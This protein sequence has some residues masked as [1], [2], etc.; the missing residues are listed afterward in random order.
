GN[1]VANEVYC[2]SGQPRQIDYGNGVRTTHGYDA[3][4]RLDALRTI[5]QP[6]TLN[7]Q[8]INSR[9]TFDGVSNIVAIADQRDASALSATDPRRDTQ[10]FRYDDLYR[11]T[12]VQYNLP[13]SSS[14]NGGAIHYGYDRIG[15]ML[16]QTSDIADV[17]N[18]RSATDLGTMVY[19]GE[20]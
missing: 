13:A 11:L 17:E 15:N 7:Q 5:S 6:V 8:L 4:Q 19:G 14:T 16:A 12:Q 2:P 9:Y 18:G 3:R 1:L 20:L 10:A